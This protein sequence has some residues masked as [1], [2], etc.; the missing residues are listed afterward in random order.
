MG[1][2][3][4]NHN[5][6]ASSVINA[7][8]DGAIQVGSSVELVSPATSELLPRV[9]T[10]STISSDLYGIVVSGDNDGIYNDGS[11]TTNP[12]FMASIKAGQTVQVCVF[13]LCLARIDS[14]SA[15]SVVM[16]SPLGQS[17][18]E[19]V[20]TFFASGS[21]PILAILLQSTTPS[22]LIDVVSVIVQRQKH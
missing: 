21:T 10:T 5:R 6:K 15:S 4:G 2:S 3:H 20:L 9:S 22:G 13:G 19:G 11:A 1:L 17:S 18:V 14:T 12:K 8:S 7:I 16:Q